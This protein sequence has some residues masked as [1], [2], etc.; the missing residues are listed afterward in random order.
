M[1]A[2]NRRLT[3][4][5]ELTSSSSGSSL[6]SRSSSESLGAPSDTTAPSVH[7]DDFGRA[8][9]P[10]AIV[11]LACRL[12]GAQSST[13]ITLDDIQGSQTS[14]YCGSFTNDYRE[15]LNKDLGY[16][17]KYMATGVGNSILA[18]RI[19]YFYD[20][21]GASVTIDTACSSSLVSFHMGNRSIQDGD[22]DISIVVGS[23]LHFDPNMF[24]TMTD[25]GFLSTDGR[26]RA[27]DASGKGYVRGEGICAVVLKQK[28]R[29]ELHGNKIRSVIRGSDVNHDGAKDGI[30]MPNSKAQENLIRKTYKNAGLST[31]DTQYF[32]AHGTGT[33]AGDPRETRAIGAVFAPNRPEPLHV[34]SVKTNIGH[35]EGASGLAGIIKTTLALEEHKIPPNM[36]FNNPNPNIDFENWK[37]AVPTKALNWEASHGFRRASINSFGYGGTN[38]HAILEGYTAPTREREISLPPGFAAMVERRPFLLPLTSHTE[39]AG[40]LFKAGLSH[41]LEDKTEHSA[42]ALARS[43]SD[44]GRTM[45]KVRSFLVEKDRDDTL[46]GLQESLTWT[47][48]DKSKIRLGF[49]F[50]GQGAQ[51][52]AMGRQ[53]IEQS[54]FFRQTLEKCDDVLQSL[55]DRPDWSCVTELLRT[56]E[57]SR[58]TQSAFSQPLCTAIQIA[59]VD[60]LAEWG[61]EPSVTVGHSAGEMGAAYAAGILSFDDAI[62]AGYYRGLTLGMKVEDAVKVPGSM[63]AVQMTETEATAELEAYKGRI[64]LAAANSPT[65]L[66]LSGDLPAILELKE[67]LSKRNIFARQLQVD[68]AYHS[69]HIA[70]FGPV[71]QQLLSKIRPR[72]PRCQMS[73]SVTARNAEP[74]KMKAA[75]W[76]S[77]LTGQVR[78][79]DALTNLLLNDNEEQNVD[80]LVEIGPHPA[81]RGPAKEVMKSLKLDIPYIASLNR[82]VPDFGSLL[83]CVGQLFAHG[84]PVDLAAANS[85][86][87]VNHLG[88][89]QRAMAGP[90]IKLPS[91]AWDHAKYWSETRVIKNNRLRK[92]RHV[93]LGVP[94]ADSVDNHP[95]WRTFLRPAELPWLS[96]HMIEGKVI[97]PAAGYI[98]MAIEAVT[99]LEKCPKTVKSVSL[100]DVSFKSA[101]PVRMDDMGTEVLLEMQPI[102]ASAKRT[103]DTWYRFIISSY[104]ESERCDEHCHGLISVE[105]GLPSSVESTEPRPTLAQLQKTSNRTTTMQKYYDHLNSMGLQYGEDFRLLSG[106][107]E[108]GPGFAMAPITFRPDQVSTAPSDLCIVHPTFLDSSFHVVFAGAESEMGRPLGEPFVPTFMKSMKVSGLF[109]DM[110][111]SDDQQR[112]WVSSNTKLPGPRVA[113]SDIAIQSDDCSKL[114]IE[115][116]GAEFTALGGDMTGDSPERTLFFRTMWQPAFSCLG[117]NTQPPKLEGLAQTMS[118]FAH[119]VPN[120][121]ILHFSSNVN[122]VKDGLSYLGGRQGS[123]RRFQSLTPFSSSKDM[124][125][126]WDALAKELPGRIEVTEPKV[127]HYDAVVIEEPVQIDITTLLKPNGFVISNGVE[128]DQHGLALLFHSG[129]IKV[130]KQQAEAH[131]SG[132]PLSLIMP[133]AVSESTDAIAST[134]EKNYDGEVNRLSLLSL[135]ESTSTL[136]DS[137][138]VLASL[139]NDL[140][141]DDA[142]DTA[143][144]Y[145]AVQK[146]LTSSSTN[147][148]WVTNGGTREAKNPQQAIILGLA[149]VARSENEKLRLVTLDFAQG[150]NIS[151]I[152]S[153]ALEVLDRNLTEDEFSH[154][155]GT[156]MIPKVERDDSRNSKLP[157]NNRGEAKL[158]RF[159]Q[160]RP[161]A[162]KIGKVGLLDSLAFGDDEQIL[163]EDLVHD[164]IEIEVKASAINFRDIAASLGIIDDYKLGDE[165][166]GIVRRVGHGVSAADFKA[167]DRIVAWRPGQGAHRSIVRN[168]AVYCQKLTDMPFGIATSFPLVLTTAHYA[169]QDVA[170]L[171]P[172]E[173]VLIHSAAGGVGQMALQVARML[174]AKV[175]ATCGSQDK[176]DFLKKHFGLD[177]DHILSSRDNSFAEGVFS[178]TSGKGVDVALNSLAGELLHATWSCIARFG[179]F[180]EI[181][182]RDI[183]ENAKIDMDPFR[184]NIS[185]ASVDMITVFEHNRPLGAR[186]FKDCCNLILEG[187][188]KIPETVIELPYA[189]AQKGFRMLQMGKHLGKVVLVAREYESVPVLPTI[190][191]NVTLFNPDKIYL[192]VGGLGGLG[193]TLAEWMVRKGARQLAFMSRSGA[194][195]PEAAATLKWLEARDITVSIYRADV[196]D[197]AAVKSCTEELGS[198][199]GGV[200]QAAMVLQDTPL[201][202]MTHQQ[203]QTSV[204]PK[205]RGTYNLHKATLGNTLD[206]FVCFSSASAI[207]GAMAQANY[208]AANTY[209]DALMS[210]RRG[211]GLKGMTMNCGMIVGVGAVAEDVALERIMKRIGYDAVNEEELLYQVEE[212]VIAQQDNFLSTPGIDEH[213]T[214]TGI[215]LT[216]KDLYWASKPLLRNLYAN[217]DIDGDAAKASIGKP[218][219]G[220]LRDAAHADERVSILTT[221]FIEKVSAVL[222]VATDIVQ[223][224]NPLSAYG[225]DSIVAIE[226]RKWFM[227]A[228]NVDVQIFDVLGSKSIT[229]LVIKAASLIKFDAESEDDKTGTPVAG[230]AEKASFEKTQQ[231]PAAATSS[232]FSQIERPRNLP[233]STFQ[234]R[235]WFQHNMLEDKSS[236]NV[237]VMCHVRGK[238]D[239]PALEAAV[240]EM[241]KRNESLRM[242]FFEGDEFS[243]QKPVPGFD[244]RLIRKDLSADSGN[245]TKSLEKFVAQL[246]HQELDIEN[247]EVLRMAMAKIEEGHYVLIMIYHHISIDR[248]SSKSMFQQV[249]SLYEAIRNEKALTTVMPPKVSYIDFTLWHEAR[250]ASP[251]LQVSI[252]FWRNNLRNAPEVSKLL[253]FAKASRPEQMDTARAVLNMNLETPMLNRMK[254]I[255]AQTGTTP[256]QYLLA[257]FRSFHYRYTEDEDLTV[258]MVDGRRPHADL[259]ETIGFFV[260]LIPIRF[261][262]GCD[263]SFD[264]LLEHTKS[265]TLEA[266]Q[267]SSVP[268]DAIVD[269]VNVEKTPS[270]FPLG[271]L[272]INYQSHG[273]MPKFK[274]QDFEISQI[275]GE[276]IPTACEMQLEALEDPDKGLDLRLEYSSTLYGFK[277]MELFFDNFLHYFTNV[278]KD[279][280]QPISEVAMCGPKEIDHLK[281]SSWNTAF[282]ENTWG[283]G[284][285]I[286]QISEIAKSAPKATAI[287]DSE[288]RSVTYENLIGKAQKI[289]ASLQQS[290]ASPGDFVGILSRPGIESISAMLGTLIAGCGYIPMDPEF[291]IDRLMFMASDASAKA[292]L[293]G[294][295]LDKVGLAIAKNIDFEPHLIPISAANSYH[296]PVRPVEGSS[297]DP[298][299]IMYTSGSTG[300]PKG[301]ALTRSNTQQ[302]LS[303]LHYDFNFNPTDKFL[304][305]SSICFDLSI[306][307][308][309]SAL[310][311]GATVCVA[312]P[313]V[314]KD[315]SL[316]AKFIRDAK[317][318]VTYNT[319]TQFA[320]LLESASEDLRQCINYRVAFFAGETLP[321][322]LAKAFYDLKTPATAYNTWSPSELVVQT[323]IHKVE[324]PLDETTNIPIGFPMA[325][326]RHYILDSKMQPLPSSMV[327]EI[328]VGG[329][330]VGA[331]YLNRPDANA[332]SFVEDPFCSEED[333]ARGWNRF[334]RTGDKGRFLPNGELEFHGRIAGDR[335]IKLRG[336]RID[337][338][339]IEHRIHLESSHI[340]KRRLVDLSVVARSRT[341]DISLTDERQLVAFLVYNQKL[342]AS[343]KQNLVSLLHEKL[344][345]HLN[346]YMLPSGY[347]FLNSLPVTI[348]GKVDR[349]ALL[350]M[351]LQL[352]YPSS[353]ST[354]L[355]NDDSEQDEILQKVVQLFKDVLKLPK[356]RQIAPTD[357]FFELGGQSILLLRAHSKIKRTFKVA[358]AL[359]ELF[360]AA[361][362][363]EMAEKVREAIAGQG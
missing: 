284:S 62:I 167:G 108:S 292:I 131:A 122:S 267:H 89:V 67:S 270:H 186:V 79:A 82:G 297:D 200:F 247:G 211:L 63:L 112:F 203:W 265:S 299:Y 182:K 91:Y 363:L 194:S 197:Y 51:S 124:S 164:E 269:A 155:D 205:V 25:L 144:H 338:G 273:K 231:A 20:L 336:F 11:G 118:V 121:T 255:C 249:T 290:G 23:S 275:D 59:L 40:N 250:L 192:L 240:G 123:R 346:Y 127:G 226:F 1:A 333:A 110:M 2:I 72:A 143:A 9:D 313:E 341:D 325:N 38:S 268:F 57:T 329:S 149:R 48:S 295:G 185:F 246:R 129:S 114:M 50:T 76:V 359:K 35:L 133:S 177:D 105:E 296:E 330:Q 119:Q 314:R 151:R 298:F 320:L 55:P 53:L 213:Q 96:Q 139:D 272:A 90:K 248:G 130:W 193:R 176:R 261:T 4:L 263:A 32:E 120:S 315:P 22:A 217:L 30:T 196:T 117:G 68:K 344:A 351:E 348:G 31:N 73:S 101:L 339:E 322:R 58:V 27:F 328:C 236:L 228:I 17:P 244:L 281:S 214:I 304:H 14:V 239:V 237:P 13:G 135:L 355:T 242:S 262:K 154:Q 187:T 146:L 233:M 95:R 303:T 5:T 45:H 316:L 311:S 199:L 317:V 241:V 181:G 140:F 212:A 158:E 84:Y 305:Q 56:K 71:L 220:T 280:R 323:T 331:G 286:D 223:P 190:Y 175:I 207:V 44:H 88:S 80:M 362:P 235:M 174:G 92:D 3:D 148:V 33:Q 225:L 345:K 132:E 52:F 109:Q 358:P 99:R 210:H 301:V 125:E 36:L 16:Y 309:F 85:N 66:T 10:T 234:R 61:I 251:E 189:E 308:I 353:T 343:E 326:C 77:N 340:G 201:N 310:T 287:E 162:L 100:K 42:A 253:P 165:C 157:F 83:S 103:S 75:Y 347:Q 238:L 354:I 34:G 156:L 168:P 179:R 43:L 142:S 332:H 198:R 134:I 93:I 69:H 188:I 327:G 219:M 116:Q 106:N 147:M 41:F 334:F 318:S 98:S 293:V 266:T 356:D 208:S 46:S 183:H 87:F 166:A 230:A 202:K 342:E 78:F 257:A 171:Q 360:T 170:R 65:S 352:I 184:K 324:Y 256:F 60:L 47:R 153:R 278:I 300:T 222:G 24:V 276:D 169:L 54:P 277:E 254:R 350:A 191:R 204:R 102:L 137:V 94:V 302:M 258:H 229:D 136:A 206:F 163:D 195:R 216:R 26:C 138:I 271:Q 152:P 282:T 159:Q 321:V 252:E 285:V 215:N 283:T 150:S 312:S 337:L 29:A 319:P 172:G 349:K 37:I 128:F 209:L 74:S 64:A 307:Q 111:H 243:E 39:K 97:F 141:F 49:V 264:R 279:H 21:H 274:T 221:A 160:S 8:D 126:L 70:P 357:N 113:T 180:I 81:L 28:S 289:A 178:L 218:L 260:N 104:D 173:T 232:E 306:V 145:E 115:M 224:G 259:E 12:P 245:D 291:A 86:L 294:E 335:Q 15:M 6:H 18:N 361:T 227:K 19:S 161:L 107:I 7:E 288:G